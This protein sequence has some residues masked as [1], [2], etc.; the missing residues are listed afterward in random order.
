MKK[1]MFGIAGVMAVLSS[2]NALTEEQCN[3]ST[4]MF[5]V[6]YSGECVPRNVCDS[7][8]KGK[9]DNDYCVRDFADTEVESVAV[10]ERLAAYYLENKLGSDKGVNCHINVPGAGDKESIF[11]QNFIPCITADGRYIVFEF[12]DTTDSNGVAEAEYVF[13]PLC[14]SLG[15]RSGFGGTY[16]KLC[17]GLT[18]E[19][20]KILGDQ[21]LDLF[22][23]ANSARRFH[24][25]TH[26]NSATGDCE[27]K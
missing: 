3:K 27:L 8:F 1:L 12:D 19:Q 22:K 24:Q 20:C 17:G 9:Y 11:G 16:G 10:A 18:E 23:M 4:S 15:G 26:F 6:K 5:W 25:L 21:L 13:R 14:K 2:A 7:K